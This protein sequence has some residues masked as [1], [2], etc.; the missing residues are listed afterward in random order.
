[1]Y[2]TPAKESVSF[3][4]NVHTTYMALV[5]SDGDVLIILLT[6]IYTAK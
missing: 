3:L 6:P 2:C 5:A 4:Y 1:L